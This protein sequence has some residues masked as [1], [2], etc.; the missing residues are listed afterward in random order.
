MEVL[1]PVSYVTSPA[2][3]LFQI[4]TAN[5][6]DLKLVAEGVAN[7]QSR[8]VMNRISLFNRHT[9]LS[10]PLANSVEIVD[11]QREVSLT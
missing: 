10:E 5:L 7:V 8:P 6:R 3:G 11:L 1:S 2:R 9:V 4:W